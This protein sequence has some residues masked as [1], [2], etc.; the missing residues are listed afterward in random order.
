MSKVLKPTE[1]LSSHQQNYHA[2]FYLIGLNPCL[3]ENV[4]AGLVSCSYLD[5]AAFIIVA[6]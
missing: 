5:H 3:S 6:S 2:L 4:A 1:S